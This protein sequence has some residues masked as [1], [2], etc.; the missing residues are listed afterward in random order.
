MVRLIKVDKNKINF[1][2]VFFVVSLVVN[3]RSIKDHNNKN[4]FGIVFSSVLKKDYCDLVINDSIYFKNKEIVT[5]ESLGISPI[6]IDAFAKEIHIKASFK[7]TV[8]TDFGNKERVVL[9]D[10]VLNMSKG[11]FIMM[12]ARMNNVD[13]RQ[14]KSKFVLD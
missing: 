6:S 11:K 13:V 4:S 3:C 1:V 14:Q 12:Q 2:L 8:K 9:L 7:G 10:T 5:S